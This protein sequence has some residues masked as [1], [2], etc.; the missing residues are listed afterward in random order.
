MRIDPYQV[1]P[2]LSQE[3]Y[4]RLKADIR[5]NGVEIPIEYD[6]FGNVLDGHHRLRICEELGITDFPINVRIGLSEQQKRSLARRLNVSRRHLSREQ[7]RMLIQDQLIET[8]ELSDRQIANELGVSNSTVSV[9]RKR[10][11]ESGHLCESHTSTGLDGKEYPRHVERKQVLPDEELPEE[12]EHRPHVVNNSGNNEWYTP[13][14]IIELARSAMGGITLDPA[15]SEVANQTVQAENY[16]TV[17]DNGLEKE[18]FGNVWLNPP[19]SAELIGKFS[20]KLIAERENY[21]QAIVLVNNA[22]ETEWFNKV[23]SI[24]SAVCFPKGRIRYY[25]PEKVSN[26]PL[27][28]QALL[29]IGNDVKSFVKKFASVGWVAYGI[30]R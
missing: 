7:M 28:G 19:Y 26:T 6:E 23:V 30:Y 14:P 9:H 16:F 17:E 8:P 4:E 25:S 20:E 3:D 5:E 12:P 15:S 11:E 1:M 2:D 24:A 29:Y 18:W 13:Q 21:E 27:Q 22:T 10:M